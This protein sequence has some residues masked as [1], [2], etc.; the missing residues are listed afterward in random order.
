MPPKKAQSSKSQKTEVK[1]A[2]TKLFSKQK[3]EEA[4]NPTIS[5]GKTKK[6]STNDP[7]SLGEIKTSVSQWKYGSGETPDSLFIS[8]WNVNGIR[9][10]INKKDLINY[11]EK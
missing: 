1:E 6:F 7:S 10:V 11:I 8:S 4:S 5:K 3:V 9:S 2:Q